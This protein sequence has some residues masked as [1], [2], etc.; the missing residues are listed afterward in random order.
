MTLFNRSSLILSFF[1]LILFCTVMGSCGVSSGRNSA[2]QR[3][4]S[5][6]F[7]FGAEDIEIYHGME[8]LLDRAIAESGKPI[9]INYHYAYTD[10][11]VEAQNIAH[12]IARKPDVLVIMPLDSKTV[13]HYIQRADDA[14]IPVIVYNRAPDSSPEI[15]PATFI[16]LD[17]VDQAYTTAVGLFS[18]VRDDG[19]LPRAVNVM[20]DLR[21]RNAVNRN[22]GLHRAAD[23]TGAIIVAAIE[24]D[25][26]PEV[27]AQRLEQVLLQ[28]PEINTVFVASD[29]LMSGV[30]DALIRH[31]RWYPY[32][33]ERHTYIGSQ[34]V[35]LVGAELVRAGYIDVNTAFDI[36]PMSTTL[37]QSIV[38]IAAGDD[39]AQQVFLI[40]GRI[41][42][43]GN[44]EMMSDLW[45]QSLENPK[46]PER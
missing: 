19:F 6:E 14:G 21:D 20:G 16:G 5:V 10:P 4:I 46:D 34:D 39:L 7:S 30:R 27:A 11:D 28:H 42:T 44:I 2:S 33:H 41:V 26:V 25:W 18:R 38:S 1:G 8:L 36:W 31:D 37:V 24:T 43:A 40:P 29:W 23:E 13:L 15:Q 12:A 45:H 32:G 3:N 17:T 9:S 35:F 22:M